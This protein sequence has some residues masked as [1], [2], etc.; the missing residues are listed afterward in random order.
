[1]GYT[2]IVKATDAEVSVNHQTRSECREVDGRVIE[3]LS[4]AH[5]V[6]VKVGAEH[7]VFCND[8]DSVYITKAT[9]KGLHTYA[10]SDE[11]TTA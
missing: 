7:A 3:T 5:D 10:I 11:E 9:A 6:L 4:T 2:V 1:M 8:G